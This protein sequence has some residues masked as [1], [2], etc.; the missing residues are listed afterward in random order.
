M[1]DVYIISPCPECGGMPI[2]RQCE[3]LAIIGRV[4]YD[5]MCED[6]H[7]YGFVAALSPEQAIKEWEAYCNQKKRSRKNAY[8]TRT[9]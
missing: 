1:S 4:G 2:V 6:C 7:T 9:D 5:V 8:T 3:E